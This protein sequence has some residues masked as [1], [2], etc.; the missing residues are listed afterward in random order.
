MAKKECPY[1]GD[2]RLKLT[3][4][5]QNHP[6]WEEMQGLQLYSCNTCRSL[7]TYPMPSPDLLSQCYTYHKGGYETKRANAKIKSKQNK[8][9]Q[10]LLRYFKVQ[11]KPGDKIAD[12]GAGEGRLVQEILNLE[13]EVY[14][15]CYDYHTFPETLENSLNPNQK[16]HLKWISLDFTTA[17]WDSTNI[18]DHVFSTAV[19]EHVPNPEKLVRD[20]YSLCKPGGNV[21]V[22]GPRIDSLIFSLF[23]TKY[24]YYLPGEH[25]TIPSIQGI[26]RMA[27]KFPEAQYTVNKIPVT[28]SV[29]Y[30]VD[31]VTR[32]SWPEPLDFV[33]RLPTGAFIL[34]IHKPISI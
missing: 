27:Q 26:K 16:K 4:K 25:L 15:D 18:Y 8:W 9:Y 10:D 22:F 32:L 2:H 20:M 34:I 31:S 24:I 14:I 19:I 1:C 5:N 13:N 3:Y 7:I 17:K 21:Y 30:M 12:F 11:F 29:K 6:Q 23:R 28:Y 33:L